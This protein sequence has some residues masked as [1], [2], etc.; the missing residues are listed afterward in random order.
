MAAGL[1]TQMAATITYL[2]R[3]TAGLPSL[4]GHIACT[5]LMNVLT[6]VQQDQ[7]NLRSMRL[8]HRPAGR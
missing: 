4:S 6:Q 2:Y 1:T 7:R 8:P 5:Q 3:L